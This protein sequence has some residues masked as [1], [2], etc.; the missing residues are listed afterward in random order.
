MK[1]WKII[2]IVFLILVLSGALFYFT[3][4]NNIFAVKPDVEKPEINLEFIEE[5]PGIQVIE[6]EHL[7]YLANEFG[8]Y[9]LHSSSGEDAV[10]VFEMTDVRISFALIINGDAHITQDIPGIIDLIIRGEQLVIARLIESDDLISALQEEIQ[11]GNIEI[12][13]ISDETT[14]AMKGYLAIYESLV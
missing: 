5:N 3:Q 14:L 8:S 9:K 4:I 2:C 7:E 6:E 1:T 10:L 13:L 12:E 11:A